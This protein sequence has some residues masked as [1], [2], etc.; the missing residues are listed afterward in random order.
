VIAYFRVPDA[1]RQTVHPA[2]F[3]EVDYNIAL[4]FGQFKAHYS[5][6]MAHFLAQH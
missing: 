1:H 3:T 4:H 6:Q 2:H 5:V